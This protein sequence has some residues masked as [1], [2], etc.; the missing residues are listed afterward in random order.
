MATQTYSTPGAASPNA[1]YTPKRKAR[2]GLLTSKVPKA[3]Q[4]K[5]KKGK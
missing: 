4:P 5:P 3:P 1:A 2:G